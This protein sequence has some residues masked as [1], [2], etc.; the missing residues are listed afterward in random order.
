M[1]ILKLLFTATLMIAIYYL[2]AQGVSINEDGSAAD[3]SAM[4]DVKS[5]DKGVL[6]PRMTTAEILA[7]STPANGLMV[8]NTSSNKPVYY[9]GTTWLNFDGSTIVGVG[10]YYQGGVV[11]WLDGSGGGLIVAIDE[12]STGASWGCFGTEIGGTSFDIGTGKAN[13]GLILA[14]CTLPGI[15]ADLC[16]G[17]SKDGFTDWFLPS[18]DELYEIFTNKATI[19]PT[20]IAEGGSAISSASHWSS[21]EN[22]LEQAFSVDGPANFDIEGKALPRIVRAVRAF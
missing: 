1:K 9:N 16:D 4:L 17:Y 6:L 21:S 20:A 22:N 5:T 12:Q 10:D 7:I 8:Y 3:G 14:G 2:S 19:D 18:R 15:A 13:T 11:F